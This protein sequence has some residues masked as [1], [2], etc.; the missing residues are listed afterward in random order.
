[1]HV[2][3]KKKNNHFPKTTILNVDEF[4]GGKN[5]THFM[6]QSVKKKKNL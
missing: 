3:T 2:Y 4:F 5:H 6:F 1:M